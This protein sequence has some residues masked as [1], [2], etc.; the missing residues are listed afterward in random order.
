MEGK[1]SQEGNEDSAFVEP[2]SNVTRSILV[3]LGFAAMRG[4]FSNDIVIE[5]TGER[6]DGP[7]AI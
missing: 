4:I 7:R 5:S 2:R 1:Y 6:K 3:P